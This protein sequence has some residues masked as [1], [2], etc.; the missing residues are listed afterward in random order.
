MALWLYGAS[1]C[2]KTE[3]KCFYGYDHS[4]DDLCVSAL[5]RHFAA[6]VAVIARV[7]KYLI[8]YGIDY[9]FEKLAQNQKH[10]ED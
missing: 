4:H 7:I 2:M 8:R 1:L 3:G 6:I 10:K 9:Y 5:R